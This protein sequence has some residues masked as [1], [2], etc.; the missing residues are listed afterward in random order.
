MIPTYFYGLLFCL[1]NNVYLC[2]HIATGTMIK[3]QLKKLA[4]EFLQAEI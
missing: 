2:N 4:R 1:R 3:E